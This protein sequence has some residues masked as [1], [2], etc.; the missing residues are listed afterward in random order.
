MPIISRKSPTETSMAWCS[1]THLSA[2]LQS[3]PEPFGRKGSGPSM[4]TSIGNLQP[5]IV[6]Q[7]RR[8]FC[9]SKRSS[10]EK[11]LTHEDRAMFR[12]SFST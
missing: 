9:E 11:N 8:L 6:L 2:W 4:P 10:K 5:K 7:A 12:R 1:T 3:A